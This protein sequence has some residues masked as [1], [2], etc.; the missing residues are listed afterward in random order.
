MKK[1]LLGL[2]LVLV[3]VAGFSLSVYA[4]GQSIPMPAQPGPLSI[5]LDISE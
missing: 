1:R 3:L 2:V 4:E 5:G